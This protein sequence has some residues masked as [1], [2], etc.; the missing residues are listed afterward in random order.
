MIFISV[1]NSLITVLII[2]INYFF[3]I[4]HFVYMITLLDFNSDFINF[5]IEVFT[6]IFNMKILLI[7]FEIILTIYL[8]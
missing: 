7:K 6:P 1:E 2:F 4:P 8:Y 3:K 5:F